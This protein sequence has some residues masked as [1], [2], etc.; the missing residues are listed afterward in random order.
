MSNLVNKKI[1]FIGGKGGVGKSTT[2]AA[3][4]LALA[5]SGHRTLIVSTDPAHNLGDIFHKKIKHEKTKL[6]ENLWGIEVDPERES[7]RYIEGVKDNLQGLVKSRMVEE[8]HRQ[9]DMASASPGADEAAL[10]DRLISIILE[11]ADQFDKI[12]FDTAPTGHTIR[13]LT[14]PELMSVWIDGMLERRKKINDNYTQLLNDG[15]PVE[16]PIY[17]IL[18]KRKNKF[19]S[20][21]EIILDGSRTG[22]VFVLNPERLPILETEQA[23]RQLD[24]YHLHV[25]TLVVNKV[26]PDHADGEF[27]AKRRKQELN[28]LKQIEGTF[29]KQELI[30]VPLFEEDVSDMEKLKIFADHIQQSIKE[31]SK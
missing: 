6:T 7:K 22:F 4:A 25:R 8:V 20:V 24:K 3:F 27:L 16:D 15:E 18:Q 30:K 2:S 13:L 10:F 5:D 14:L 1:V 29:S 11:E 26:L 28:Y 17:E 9:I 12:I 21:R 19:A 31:E 23:I